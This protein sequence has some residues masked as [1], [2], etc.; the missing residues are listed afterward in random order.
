MSDIFKKIYEENLWKSGESR[1]GAGSEL[2]NTATLRQELPFV[3]AKYDIKSML[4]LPC[5]DFNWMKEVDL[6]DIVYTG[7]DIVP[8]L[9]KSNVEQYP[10]R[11]FKVM[12]IV[13]S[14]LPIV[15]LIF[16]RD[17]LGHL[18]TPNVHKAI[19]N[20]KKSGSKYLLTTCFTKYTD[21][22]DIEDGGWKCINLM[23]PPF[24]MRPLYL[25]NE[26]CLEG[27]PDYRDKCMVLFKL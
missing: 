18:N 8:A 4:D 22:P 25:I 2:A 24:L 12:D 13:T 7:A 10:D 1:S 20:M 26:D 16:V 3:F 6:K 27:F 11:A 5:G 19:E 14:T 23:I 17:C 9:I 21:N 15:D